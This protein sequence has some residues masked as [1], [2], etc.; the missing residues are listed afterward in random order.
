MPTQ[1]EQIAFKT[2]L[3]DEWQARNRRMIHQAFGDDGCTHLT[4]WPG[5]GKCLDCQALDRRAKHYWR[6]KWV[7]WARFWM[8]VYR[9]I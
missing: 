8:S 9:W 7:W 1:A 5:H 4:N 3:V 6:K 2:K